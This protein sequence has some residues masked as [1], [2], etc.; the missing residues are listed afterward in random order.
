MSD[1]NWMR[2]DE[3]KKKK[4]TKQPL[5]FCISIT[6]NSIFITHNSKIVGPQRESLFGFVF[7][8]CFHHS[9]LWFFSDELWKL[10]THFRCFQVMETKLWWQ[11]CKYTHIEGPTSCNFWV[12]SPLFFFFFFFPLFFLYNSLLSLLFGKHQFF[13]SF[14]FFFPSFSPFSSQTHKKKSRNKLFFLCSSL[15]AS[16]LSF[17]LSFLSS[18]SPFSS[19]THKKKSWNKLFFFVLH[20]K[21]HDEG[22]SAAGTRRRDGWS[23]P[24][25]EWWRS[26]RELLLFLWV[27]VCALGE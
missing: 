7:K 9:I 4:T 8:F 27:R 24:G 1:E 22:D 10:K 11:S 16:V 17:F 26:T 20:C 6:H 23:S 12:H 19:Q 13:I 25:D 14:F 21:H 5:G 2:S 15:Q 3:K 18:F